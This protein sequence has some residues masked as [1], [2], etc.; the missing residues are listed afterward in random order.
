[1]KLIY[2]ECY[3]NYG[4]RILMAHDKKWFKEALEDVCR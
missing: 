4:D 1:M 3:R 2:H